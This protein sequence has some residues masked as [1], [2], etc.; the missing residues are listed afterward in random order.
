MS[1]SEVA[2]RALVYPR[3]GSNTPESTK[4]SSLSLLITIDR[5]ITQIL[6]Q[7]RFITH[8]SL[9]QDSWGTFLGGLMWCN[10]KEELEVKA[11]TLRHEHKPQQC[12]N[13][14]TCFLICFCVW[15]YICVCLSSWVCMCRITE[16]WKHPIQIFQSS[17]N[18]TL[19]SDGQ[20]CAGL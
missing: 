15:V 19:M 5:K 7:I 11:N 2:S 20:L 3:A 10:L 17:T 12:T 8:F 9:T 13:T 1:E 18:P 6:V 14:M 4:L 16:L